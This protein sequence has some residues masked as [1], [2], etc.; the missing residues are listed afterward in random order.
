MELNAQGLPMAGQSF[1]F[2][3]EGGIG[4]TTINVFVDSKLI[5]QH[6]CDDPPCHEMAMIPPGTRGATLRVIATD[7]VGNTQTFEYKVVDSDAGASG[8]MTAGG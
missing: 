8:T 1:Y 3:V 7:S 4:K 2:N 5:L 6:D